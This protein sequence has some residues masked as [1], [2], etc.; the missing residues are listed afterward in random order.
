[1]S[2]I[3]T[4]PDSLGMIVGSHTPGFPGELEAYEDVDHVRGDLAIAPI[5]G[6]SEPKCAISD[7]V[8]VDAAATRYPGHETGGAR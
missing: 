4:H 5:I 2:A 7:V 1:M 3:C 6:E 8:E